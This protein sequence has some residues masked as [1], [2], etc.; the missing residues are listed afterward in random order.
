MTRE[1]VYAAAFALA[2]DHCRRSLVEP[3]DQ[4][5]DD[6]HAWAVKTADAAVAAR[7]RAEKRAHE[8]ID[9]QAKGG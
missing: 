8:E 4:T 7:E 6:A 1:H 2:V 9:E 5:Y 3:N